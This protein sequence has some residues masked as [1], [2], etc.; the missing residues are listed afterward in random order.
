MARRCESDTLSHLY[1]LV[2]T[3]DGS[4]DGLG[5]APLRTRKLRQSLRNASFVQD[6]RIAEY[7]AVTHDGEP[8][9]WGRRMGGV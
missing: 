1:K 4:E 2:V 9:W 5:A 7:T 3:P 8:W 6:D